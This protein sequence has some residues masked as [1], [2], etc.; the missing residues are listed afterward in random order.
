MNAHENPHRTTTTKTTTAT[1]EATPATD[2][3]QLELAQSWDAAYA[4]RWQAVRAEFH[5]NWR[6]PNRGD[7]LIEGRETQDPASLMNGGGPSEWTRADREASYGYGAHARYPQFRVWNPELEAVL[8]REWPRLNTG[9]SWED[10]REGVH[11]GWDFA[12]DQAH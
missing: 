9:T 1:Y 6:H 10:A 5:R 2:R 3:E 7:S 8:L 4:A 11:R 12:R